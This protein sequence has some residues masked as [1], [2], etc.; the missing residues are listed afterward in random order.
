MEL[1][2]LLTIGIILVAVG[3]MKRLFFGKDE[4]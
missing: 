4:K 2:D 3:F 1:I